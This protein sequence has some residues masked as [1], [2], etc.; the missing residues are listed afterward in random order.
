VI[1]SSR[2]A[3][4]SVLFTAWVAAV[5]M[6][7][8]PPLWITLALTR[9]REGA[10]LL[11]SRWARRVFAVCGCP[12]RVTGIEHLENEHGAI[13]VANHSSYLDSVVLLAVIATDYRFVANQRELLRPFVG[14]V[15]RKGRHLLVDRK[16]MESRVACTRAMLDALENGT[17]VVLFPEGT[18]STGHMQAFRNGAFRTSVKSGRPIVPVAISG[19]SRILPRRP[20]L[21]ARSNIDIRVLPPIRPG[22]AP[23]EAVLLRQRTVAAI[24]DSLDGVQRASFSSS[25]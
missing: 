21:L 7:V 2:D 19:T 22:T 9:S 10:M 23:G 24:A 1:D 20:R 16:S 13:I 17:S 12:L 4:G 6:A 8:I 15:L 25:T 3:R 5:L 18:R 11:V 14:L